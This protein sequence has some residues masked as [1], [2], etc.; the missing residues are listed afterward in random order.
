MRS[1]EVLLDLLYASWYLEGLCSKF[2]P[3]VGATSGNQLLCQIAVPTYVLH[4][5]KKIFECSLI[6]ANDCALSFFPLISKNTPDS[7]GSG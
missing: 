4:F 7:S 3:N 1:V 5:D 2:G 6:N